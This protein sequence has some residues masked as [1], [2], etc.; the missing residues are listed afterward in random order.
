M[1]VSKVDGEVLFGHQFLVDDLQFVSKNLIETCEEWPESIVDPG[2]ELCQNKVDQKVIHWHSHCFV[3]YNWVDVQLPVF[4]IGVEV[5][6]NVKRESVDLK[7]SVWEGADEITKPSDDRVELELQIDVAQFQSKWVWVWNLT[8]FL[9]R[10][11]L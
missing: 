6:D 1:A 11:A 5:N 7:H 10:E 8:N 9:R 4:F 3:G 2:F